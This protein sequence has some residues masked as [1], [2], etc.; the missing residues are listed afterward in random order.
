MIRRASI[1]VAIA[2]AAAASGLGGC[3]SAPTESTGADDQSLKH[4]L[5][6]PGP[7]EYVCPS[8]PKLTSLDCSSL[9]QGFAI[10]K[11]TSAPCSPFDVFEFHAVWYPAVVDTGIVVPSLGSSICAYPYGN[12]ISNATGL[13]IDV[14]PRPSDICELEPAYISYLLPKDNSFTITNPTTGVV[15][16]IPGSVVVDPR[17][18]CN[19]P[20]GAKGCGTCVQQ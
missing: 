2:C 10:P 16:T 8:A 12:I 14:Y 7:P 1:V 15:R 3:S 5:P 9:V 6:P 17:V 19:V 4:V 13:P 18:L 11:L 20:D